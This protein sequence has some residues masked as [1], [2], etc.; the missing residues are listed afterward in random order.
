MSAFRDRNGAG[1][2]V[3]HLVVIQE[4]PH[5][6]RLGIIKSTMT[7]PRGEQRI[8]VAFT[9]A[10]TGESMWYR[11]EQVVRNAVQSMALLTMQMQREAREAGRQSAERPNPMGFDLTTLLITRSF[12]STTCPCC[13]RMKQSSNAFCYKCFKSLPPSLQQ[14]LYQRFGEGYEEAFAVALAALNVRLPRIPER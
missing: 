11:P 13:G 7:P 3:G 4:G 9:T 6:G 10:E 14:A 2:T 12:R 5:D 8:N 1:I